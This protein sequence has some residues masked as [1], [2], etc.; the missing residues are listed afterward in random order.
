[1]KEIISYIRQQLQLL[2]Q[3]QTLVWQ[4]GP[5]WMYLSLILLL[6][7]G[8]VPV[9][10]LLLF[11]FL[12]DNLSQGMPPLWSEQLI[13]LIGL[14]ILALM[15]DICRSAAT[16]VQEIQAGLITDRVT[17]KLH[18]KSVEVD[19]DYYEDPD[20]HD[21]LH[22]VQSQATHR[23][24]RIL[25]ALLQGGRGLISLLGTM[26][27][28]L[29]IDAP[30][31]G[32]LVLAA[33][34]MFVAQV[35]YARGIYM[36]SRQQTPQERW[37]GY[38]NHI[39][40][41]TNYAK[42]IRL[43]DLG[44]LFQSRFKQLRQAIRQQKQHFLM[45]RFWVEGATQG[46]GSVVTVIALGILLWHVYQNKLS[47]GGLVVG[48]QALQ[49]GQVALR[50]TW[51][52][53]AILYENN[54]FLQE[55]Q[56]FL[57]LQPQITS[58]LVPRPLLYPVQG[59]VE[60]ERVAFHYPRSTRLLFS[61]LSFKI[62]AGETV[63]LVGENGAGKTTLIKLLCRLYDPIAGRICLDDMDLK[64]LDLT[65][66]R[67]H[68]SVVFQDYGQYH[69]TVQDNIG[70]GQWQQMQDEERVRRAAAQIGLDPLIA[71]L[72]QSYQTVLGPL[73]KGGEE[74]SLGEWQKIAIARAIFRDGS[75]VIL[76]EPTSA[77]DPEA[78]AMVIEQFRAL[79]RGKTA[80]MVSHRLST[81]H[82]ADRIL[83]LENGR[84][85]EQGTHRKLMSQGG[86]YAHL[87]KT[88]AR[89]YH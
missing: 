62:D 67:G 74:L 33:F 83:V 2:A 37:A 89:Y 36:L 14:G 40:T 87:F 38:W 60:F 75:I 31:V 54:L 18:A 51:G 73:F 3:A 85:S 24:A 61:D 50:E 11:K 64:H 71:Q 56:R 27:L 82:F 34:P 49:R 13:L 30:L 76:D 58:P 63:A 53:L 46:V 35:K 29:S 44:E 42:E 77:L 1:M 78:E 22:L 86:L 23:P 17:E 26:I 81:V 66:L 52:Q 59:Q 19:L 43:F 6:L 32:F 45:Q 39:L 28:L 25:K 69:C 5:L 55:L 8:I 79:T 65:V 12:I 20:Y 21:A 57:N 9:L 7:V 4:A 48:F 72:P 68:I 16:F 10:S 70:F 41:K 15:G 84:I 88:Q 80:L 47:L